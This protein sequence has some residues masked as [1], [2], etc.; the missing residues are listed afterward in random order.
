MILPGK[1]ILI[2]TLDKYENG[3]TRCYCCIKN[4]AAHNKR[5]AEVL[6][7]V[8]SLLADTSRDTQLNLHSNHD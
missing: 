5:E 1:T 4:T 8:I 3:S 6:L 7:I 2:A